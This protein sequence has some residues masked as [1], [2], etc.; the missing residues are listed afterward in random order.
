LIA[1]LTKE[2]H[3][4]ERKQ[5]WIDGGSGALLTIAAAWLLANSSK[6]KQTGDS[7]KK[8]VFAY[9]VFCYKF[10]AKKFTNLINK[11]T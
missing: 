8:P 6:Q 3:I 5:K 7:E 10:N 11:H 9:L 4:N 1:Q 2:Q